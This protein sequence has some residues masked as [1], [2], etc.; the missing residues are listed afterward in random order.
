MYAV[1][2]LRVEKVTL[3]LVRKRVC[4][5]GISSEL[6]FAM[7]STAVPP[8]LRSLVFFATTERLSK[9]PTRGT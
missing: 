6:A 1:W 7:Q 9:A 3:C 5:V 2:V 8:V 4:L